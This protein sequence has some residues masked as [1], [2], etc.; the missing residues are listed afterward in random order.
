M[1]ASRRTFAVAAVFTAVI[2]LAA[3]AL[4]V[5]PPAGSPADGECPASWP[6]QFREFQ[7]AEA[8]LSVSE[9]SGYP[10]FTMDAEAA[11]AA[12]VPDRAIAVMTE[13]AAFQT[14]WAQQAYIAHNS[15]SAAAAGIPEIQFSDY[16]ALHAFTETA[17]RCRRVEPETPGGV[18]SDN[19]G[20]YQPGGPPEFAP[21]PGRNAVPGRPGP[22]RTAAAQTAPHPCGDW[23][24]PL[25]P[26]EPPESRRTAPDAA[27]GLRALGYH[28]TAAYVRRVDGTGVNDYTRPRAYRSP[29]GTCR[30]PLFRNH[31]RID[32]ADP[33][34]YWV[35]YAEPNPEVFAPGAWP[36]PYP[37]WPY[38]VKWWHDTH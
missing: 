25:P 16:P 1:A 10:A 7:Q 35:Q 8:F 30:A 13:V 4:G 12:G 23:A 28:I 19:P 11:R 33:S 36:W 37:A 27:A 5:A 29:Y 38:Y 20:D 22:V 17:T 24:N 26:L 9:S 6:E 21:N 14:D 34:R 31:A 32:A 15:G 2:A 18:P 3:A